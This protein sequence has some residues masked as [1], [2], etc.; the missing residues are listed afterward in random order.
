MKADWFRFSLI[1]VVVAVVSIAATAYLSKLKRT[2]RVEPET[3]AAVSTHVPHA[4]RFIASSQRAGENA[5][6]TTERF[7]AFAGVGSVLEQENAFSPTGALLYTRRKFEIAGDI[8]VEVDDAIHAMTA[9]K[10]PNSDLQRQRRLWDPSASC[11]TTFDRG[12]RLN[13]AVISKEISLG[14]EVFK[15]VLDQPHVRFTFWRAPGLGCTELRT[16]VEVKGAGGEVIMTSDDRATSVELGEP[17]PSLF[18]LPV[19]YDNVSPSER[20]RRFE[21]FAGRPPTW[22]ALESLEQGDELYEKY[23]FSPGR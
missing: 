20:Y 14:F 23:A 11:A 21:Q 7:L 3:A 4:V 12:T 5:V 8:H 10:A 16:M 18:R 15:I 9:I 17:D 1:L 19:D 6:P 2:G 13:A 22:Q